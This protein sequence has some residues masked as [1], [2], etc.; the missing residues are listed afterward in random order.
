MIE[1]YHGLLRRVYSIIITKIPGI[2]PD[3]VLQ[4]SFKAINDSVG[5]NRLV[6]TLLVFGIYLR[7]TKSDAPSPSIT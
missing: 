6:F 3:S 7:I 5:P 2:K 1:R 4:I